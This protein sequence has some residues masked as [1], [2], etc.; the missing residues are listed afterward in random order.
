[1][2]QNLIQ[3]E[4]DMVEEYIL[5]C[6]FGNIQNPQV[7]STIKSFLALRGANLAEIINSYIDRFEDIIKP[8]LKEN[9]YIDGEK[10][11]KLLEVKLNQNISLSGDCRLIDVARVF[12]QQLLS[13]GSLIR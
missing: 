3:I 8:L 11:S 13:L 10:L 5:T 12:E 7:N 9:G 1:M 2:K 4:L 6:L